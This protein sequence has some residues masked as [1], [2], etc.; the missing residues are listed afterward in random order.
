MEDR[1]IEN[2]E[3]IDVMTRIE[4]GIGQEKGHLQDIIV[5]IEIRVPVTV[6]Q[7]QDV[8]LVQIET[9]YSVIIVENINHYM[10]DCPSAREER[11]F[12]QLQQMLNMEAEEQTYRQESPTENHRSPLNL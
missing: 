4:V 7:D 6:D 8:E 9:G 10:R 1:I 5:V 3:M 12:K 11:D 2:I